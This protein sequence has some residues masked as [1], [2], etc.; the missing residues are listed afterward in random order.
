[1]DGSSQQRRMLLNG[2]KESS[3]LRLGPL[4]LIRLDFLS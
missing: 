1:M 4:N 2:C 3:S